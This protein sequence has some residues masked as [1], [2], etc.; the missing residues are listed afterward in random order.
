M[1]SLLV[2]C[3]LSKPVVACCFKSRVLAHQ[4]VCIQGTAIQQNTVT[5]WGGCGCPHA[6]GANPL[7]GEHSPT[8]PSVATD[9][10]FL[11]KSPFIGSIMKHSAV[12]LSCTSKSGQLWISLP[13][14]GHRLL[15]GQRA[16][17]LSVATVAF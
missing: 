1:K 11:P 10:S 8:R 16:G 13:G 5:A 15:S 14:S 2:L 6:P 17:R 9:L 12:L 7:L 3:L 4:L